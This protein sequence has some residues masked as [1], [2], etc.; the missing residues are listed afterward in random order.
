MES[1]QARA[2]R[3][4]RRLFLGCAGIALGG[5]FLFL[6]ARS[7]SMTD[8]QAALRR[9]DAN[10]LG[11]GV[12]VYLGSISLRCLRWGILLRATGS[13]KW[14][15]AAEA[16]IFGYT[17]NYVLP[18]RLGEFFRADY[19]HRIFHLSRFTALGT[20]VVERVCD[21]VVLVVALW[22]SIAAILLST[23]LPSTDASWVLAVG[24]ASA[25]LFGAATIFVLLSQRIELR[26]FNIMEAI[27]ARWDRLVVGISSAS[28]GRMWTI[29]LYSVGIW[30]LEV[31]TVESIVRSFGVD[32]SGA[33]AVMLLGLASL[34]TLVPTAPGY[35]GTYQLVFGHV[36]RIFGYPDTVAFLAASAIQILCFGTVTVL[37]GLV[38][39]SRSGLTMWRAH[40]WADPIKS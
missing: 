33:Q 40:R 5:L 18:G 12:A 15:H 7:V 26:R 8:L 13:V 9:M 24:V 6:A 25:V 22:A 36:F 34:S 31:L 37:G 3:F 29:I 16:L 35:I 20:I 14:R 27:A 28:R 11:V 39:L 2:P 1:G 23:D 32:L 38:L 17:A 19:A 10:W 21:G 4:W 30:S